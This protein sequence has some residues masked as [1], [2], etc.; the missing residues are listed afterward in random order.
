MTAIGQFL[1]NYKSRRFTDYLAVAVAISFPWSTSATSIFLALW[2]LAYLPTFKF[3]DLRKELFTPAGGLPVLLFAW[4]AVGILWADASWKESIDGLRQFDKVLFIP[5]VVAYF[6]RSDFAVPAVLAFIASCVVLLALSV[7]TA[8]WPELQWWRSWGPGVPVKNYVTQSAEF[9]ISA[10]CLFY[11]SVDA[12]KAHAYRFSIVAIIIA[13]AFI[14]FMLFVVTSRTEL[15]GI[16]ALVV[17]FGARLYGWKGLLGGVATLCIIVSISWATSTYLRTR[18]FQTE[19]DMKTYRSD[20]LITSTGYRL[21]FWKKSIAFISTAPLFGHGTGSIKPLFERAAVGKTGISA[22]VTSNPHNQI[23][24]VAIQ[25]GVIGT[26]ILCGMWLA[27]LLM[28]TGRGAAAWFGMAVVIQNFMG[29]LFNTH[30]FDFTEG[31]IYVCCVG[32]LGG[33]C[34]RNCDSSRAQ[35]GPR[36][37]YFEGI[38]PKKWLAH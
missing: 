26:V 18:I 7:V 24:A 11:I 36:M 16:A 25:L 17:A 38:L 37:R 32:A 3:A 29:S 35:E 15:V 33:A 13:G 30:L 1:H 2:L 34:L 6:R 19:S 12:W 14:G 10:F 20:I 8:F 23:F 27:H 22:V 4:A 28:F 31:W 5:V 9:A 21:E